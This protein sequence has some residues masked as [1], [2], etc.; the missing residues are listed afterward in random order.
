LSKCRSEGTNISDFKEMV[1]CGLSAALSAIQND[2]DLPQGLKPTIEGT[3][4]R[5][6]AAGLDTR[7]WLDKLE[8]AM[9]LSVT[10]L[11]MAPAMVQRNRSSLWRQA[12]DTVIGGPPRT[13][14]G[15]IAEYLARHQY[16][17]SPALRIELE[18]RHVCV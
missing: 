8:I 3:V 6:R 11:T 10:Q 1:E 17:L 9:N 18:R 13:A 16:D 5:E 7:V 12:I 15:Q 14:A 2:S 4:A